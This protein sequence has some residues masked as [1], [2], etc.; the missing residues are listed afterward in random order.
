MRDDRLHRAP[1]SPV[2]EKANKK[3]NMLSL[4]ITYIFTINKTLNKNFAQN[5]KLFEMAQVLSMLNWAGLIVNAGI[6]MERHEVHTLH[7]PSRYITSQNH[8]AIR[9]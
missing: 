9:V 8:M 2:Y 1:L 6:L 5:P 4:L 7:K 3:R